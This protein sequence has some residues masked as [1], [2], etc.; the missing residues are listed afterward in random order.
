MI[1]NA[2][3]LKLENFIFFRAA[4]LGVPVYGVGGCLKTLCPEPYLEISVFLYNQIFAVRETRTA[5]AFL[6]NY[7]SGTIGGVKNGWLLPP[8]DVC[9]KNKFDKNIKF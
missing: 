4:Y 5:S 9:G 2:A 3:K 1:N 7:F 6:F 8:S